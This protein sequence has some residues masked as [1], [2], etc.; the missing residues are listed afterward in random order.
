ML[1]FCYDSFGNVPV[2]FR[3][4]IVELRPTKFFGD[5]SG[6]FRSHKVQMQSKLV[7]DCLTFFRNNKAVLQ[8]RKFL[9]MSFPRSN[10]GE[11]QPGN[12]FANVLRKF[13][14]NTVELR[15]RHV[16]IRCQ[17]VIEGIK[18]NCGWGSLLQLSWKKFEAT[19]RNSSSDKNLVR[20]QEKREAKFFKSS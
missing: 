1:S 16:L 19:M 14:S 7:L 6:F 8:L 9:E 12:F 4:R 10:N 3:S 17:N 13:R 2:Y 15:I 11:V 5:V 20:S 18:W